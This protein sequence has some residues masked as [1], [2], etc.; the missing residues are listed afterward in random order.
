[1]CPLCTGVIC[2]AILD[3]DDAGLMKEP[4]AVLAQQLVKKA[5][6]KSAEASLQ[7]DKYGQWCAIKLV[8]LKHQIDA[9]LNEMKEAHPLGNDGVGVVF[10]EKVLLGPIGKSGQVDWAMLC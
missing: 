3:S 2:T 5:G 8:G 10:H 1:M 7:K 6:L 4:A 9:A